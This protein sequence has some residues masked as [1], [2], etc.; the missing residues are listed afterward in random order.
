MVLGSLIDAGVPLDD[1]RR[2]LGSLAIASD[3]VWTERVT[4][5]GVSATKFCVRDE[6]PAADRA[7]DHRGQHA[8]E[9][10]HDGPRHYHVHRTLSEIAQLIDGSALSDAGKQRAKD[11]FQ[12][13]GEAEASVHGVSVDE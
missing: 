10:P 4:R 8:H 3:T 12:R 2:A 1:V 5:A 9:H 13:L 11:L 6:E 7:D